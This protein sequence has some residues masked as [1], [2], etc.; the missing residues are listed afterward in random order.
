[1]RSMRVK[2]RLKFGASRFKSPVFFIF[3]EFCVGLT[4]GK[5]QAA[6][7]CLSIMLPRLAIHMVKREKMETGWWGRPDGWTVG[8]K[9]LASHSTIIIFCKAL[10]QIELNMA[11]G[12]WIHTVAR[13]CNQKESDLSSKNRS[14]KW[15]REKTGLLSCLHN[16]SMFHLHDREGN[17]KIHLRVTKKWVYF[18]LGV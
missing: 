18:W 2:A 10:K 5:D 15:V 7:E 8:R 4:R 16:R 3:L 13:K 9:L 14:R 12:R 17:R 1:M 6:R 11:M